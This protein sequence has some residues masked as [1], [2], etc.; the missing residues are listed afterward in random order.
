MGSPNYH[1]GRPAGAPTAL[2]VHTMGGSLAGCDAWF[3]QSISQVSAHYGVGLGGELH[4]Y[5]RL[6][7]VAWANGVLELGNTWPG[8]AGI[9][10]NS[11]SVSIETEDRGMN[12]MPVSD[13]QYASTLA[14]ARIALEHFPQLK[15]VMPH[16]VVSPRSR[17]NCCGN[18]WIRS[19]R[20][21]DLA[22]A[23]GLEPYWS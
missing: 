3:G 14:V 21:A 16:T 23:L 9:N 6:N 19:G 5:V 8:P 13:E 7:D 1:R 10:P 2:V 22:L 11:L 4:Q 12:N 15:Y 20:L 17:P 18:R